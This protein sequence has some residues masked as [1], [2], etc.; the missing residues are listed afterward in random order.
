MS[1]E[2]VKFD[3]IVQS[4][5]VHVVVQ[6]VLPCTVATVVECH[7]THLVLLVV[8][9]SCSEDVLVILHLVDVLC[10]RLPCSILVCKSLHCDRTVLSTDCKVI[11]ICIC[12]CDALWIRVARYVRRLISLS[13]SR[14]LVYSLHID[15]EVAWSV[16]NLVD[17][18][19]DLVPVVSS[20]S[21]LLV[22]CKVI[23]LAS[24]E[25]SCIVC[26]SAV[27]VTRNESIN[28]L[29]DLYYSH[30]AV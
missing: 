6:L 12:T 9:A 2:T 28:R 22:E 1:D 10:S 23:L 29:V 4:V 14:D 5:A 17:L 26:S 21:E 7:S 15:E 16:V 25:C 27:V 18:V 24:W 8:D 19:V 20:V 13:L 30:I 3:T 11:S